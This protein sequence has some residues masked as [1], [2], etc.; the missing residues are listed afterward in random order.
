MAASCEATSIDTGQL[1]DPVVIRT[2]QAGDETAFLRL[3]EE[4]IATL[5]TLEDADHKVLGNPQE[6]ILSPGG[7][8]LFATIGG[9][10]VGCCALMLEAEREY[11]VA[12]M[13]VT[14]R[15]RGRGIGRKLLE[16][17]VG[18]GRR[19]GAK[20][21]HLDTNSKLKDAIHLYEAIGFQHLPAERI[22]PSPY[23]RSNVSME[24]FLD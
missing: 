16:A 12:K 13:A 20:R 3:N 1:T 8:I 10:A 15:Y 7:Q 2:F 23:T 5:F 18:E 24:M 19:M 11:E 9:E 4:W 22:K 14:P 21:L 17:I 6:Y